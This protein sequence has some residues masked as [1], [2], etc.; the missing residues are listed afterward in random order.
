M[1][2]RAFKL[3]QKKVYKLCLRSGVVSMPC[4]PEKTRAFHLKAVQTQQARVSD[5]GLGTVCDEGLEGVADPGSFCSTK[6]TK[7]FVVPIWSPPPEIKTLQSTTS[8]VHA[9]SKIS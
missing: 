6:V 2:M 7:G 1:I 3:S 8:S 5:F 9:C 4:V